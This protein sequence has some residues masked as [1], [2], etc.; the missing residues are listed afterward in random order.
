VN[1]PGQVVH[2]LPYR[3]ASVSGRA[4]ARL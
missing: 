2:Q 3:A 4:P 1:W